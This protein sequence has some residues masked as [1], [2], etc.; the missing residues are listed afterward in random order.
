MSVGNHLEEAW[1]LYQK[2]LEEFEKAKEKSDGVVLRDACGKGWLSAL[3]ATYALLVKRGVE[4]E[5]LPQADRGRR[6]M[7]HKYAEKEL[8][9]YYFSLRD[10]LHMEGY[11]NG[12]LD[13]DEVQVRLDDLNQ[14]IQ[15]IEE[16]S[17]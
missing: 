9:L 14:Y 3:E 5:D 11:Y 8:E 13:F 15:K 4:E 17:R 16:A 2:A 12:S 6:F 10:N 1:K 7:V